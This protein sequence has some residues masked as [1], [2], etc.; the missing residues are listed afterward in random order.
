MEINQRGHVEELIFH[1]FH[2]DEKKRARWISQVR[3]GLKNFEWGQETRVCSNHFQDGKPTVSVTNVVT[4]NHIC[5]LTP[6]NVEVTSMFM[7]WS[8]KSNRQKQH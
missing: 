6:F 2:K 8:A 4:Q 5:P 1:R 7:D 3:K